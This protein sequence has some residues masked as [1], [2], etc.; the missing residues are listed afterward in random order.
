VKK[1][2]LVC[3]VGINDADYLI[4]KKSR[5]DGKQKQ[6]WICPFYRVWQ[7]MLSRCYS[8]IVQEIHPTYIDCL[9][10]E[11]WLIFSN[12]R[13]WMITQNW[14][15]KQL[16]KDLLIQSN[17]I[18][19]PETCVFVDRVTNIFITDSGASRGAWSIGVSWN[20]QAKKFKSGCSNPFIK[21]YE[22][23]GLFTCPNQAHQAWRKRKHEHACQLADL[24]SDPRVAQAL[25]IRYA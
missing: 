5:I 7:N 4:E 8:D 14:E 12:F 20:K 19:S 16:D 17:K 25:R 3:G 23:L 10:T 1:N 21:K 2:K 18:Y 6:V 13:E 11:E 15:G 9:V 24:Q 22:Y